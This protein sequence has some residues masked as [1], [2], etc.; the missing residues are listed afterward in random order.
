MV[1][2]ILGIIVGLIIIIIAYIIIIDKYTTYLTKKS[3]ERLKK[4][5]KEYEE[6]LK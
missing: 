2:L 1:N 3:E 4:I 6:K 5:Y